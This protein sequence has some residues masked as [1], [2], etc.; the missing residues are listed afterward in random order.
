MQGLALS[1]PR[2]EE[3]G[4]WLIERIAATGS[5]VQRRFGG[6][7]AGEI[8][9]HRFLDNARV[10]AG[11]ILES[12]GAGTMAV[13]A[14]RRVLAVQDTTEVN[15]AGRSGKRRGLGP[16]GNG[17]APGFF[18]HPV[19]MVDAEEEAVLG[20]LGAEIWTR[21][22]G[23]PA[24]RRSRGLGAKESRRWLTGAETAAG[25]LGTAR[26]VIVVGDRESDI[27]TVFARRPAGLGLLVR[28]AQNRKLASGGKLFDHALAALGRMPVAV[29]AK[30]GQKTRTA[31]VTLRAGPVMLARPRNGAEPA[32]PESLCL[33]AVEAVEA[34]PPA[35]V[36]GLH[37]RLYTTLPANT[38]AEAAEVVRLYRLRWRIEELFRVLKSDGLALGDTQITAAARLF[39]LAAL[40]LGAAARILQ[41]TDARDGGPRPATD[42]VDAAL[43][44]AIAAIGTTLER[45]TARQQNPHPEGSLAWLAWIAARLGGWNCYYKPPGPK[46]MAIG[47]R[48]L[49][50]MLHGFTLAMEYQHV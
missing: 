27:Y 49:A 5:L 16:A 24:A 10:S 13:C 32:D 30:P 34:D 3:R 11:A 23:C 21:A 48:Q 33:W 37:W 25:L 28:I 8:A 35:G 17:R 40:A 44:P 2:L 50:T 4:S 15:F 6:D 45:R 26:E 47:W 46:T 36:T 19:V 12:L 38:A 9:S 22:G 41:L 29:A 18:I 31:E 43:I 42:V 39:K 1:D 14:G 7:R 20:I